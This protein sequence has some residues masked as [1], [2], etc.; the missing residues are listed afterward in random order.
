MCHGDPSRG[1]YVLREG[2]AEATVLLPGGEKLTVAKL[3]LSGMC[4]GG[5]ATTT[6]DRGTTP[7]GPAHAPTLSPPVLYVASF[8]DGGSIRRA[9]SSCQ[10][11]RMDR[12][13]ALIRRRCVPERPRSTRDL[14]A[15]AHAG[16]GELIRRQRD[17]FQKYSNGYPCG[18]AAALSGPEL[19][20]WIDPELMESERRPWFAQLAV[21]PRGTP[22]ETWSP[23]ARTAHSAVLRVSASRRL[24]P[25]YSQWRAGWPLEP[26]RTQLEGSRQPAVTQLRPAMLDRST[27]SQNRSTRPTSH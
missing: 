16:L 18:W 12:E 15:A 7:A 4:F 25:R 24:P 9:R 23:P 1:T 13:G 14:A 10:P 2:A 19:K 22:M 17:P 6:P 21:H 26:E 27:S 20:V 3:E 5:A 11:K 8:W